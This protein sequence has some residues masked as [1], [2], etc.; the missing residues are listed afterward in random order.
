MTKTHSY[1]GKSSE[2]LVSLI[3]H[4]N[5][6]N[7]MVG[8]DFVFGTP[9]VY[10][11]AV[12]NTRVELIAIA[13]TNYAHDEVYYTRLNIDRLVEPVNYQKHPVRLDTLNTTTHEILGRINSAFGID[14]DEHEVVN[15]PITHY[16][17]HYTLKIT[18]YSLA[19]LESDLVFKAHHAIDDISLESVIKTTELNALSFIAV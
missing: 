19:W 1:A 11:D 15:E 13:S 16:Q 18:Q 4:D 5:N 12:R 8:V 14:L 3:N 10:E 2:R 9:K 6:T 17:T 7:L